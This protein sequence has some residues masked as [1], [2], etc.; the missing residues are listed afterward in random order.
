MI[1]GENQNSICG[2]TILSNTWL[3]TA[4]HCVHNYVGVQVRM[5]CHKYDRCEAI[6]PVSRVII[7]ADYNPQTLESDIAVIRLTNPVTFST[8]IQP[9]CLPASDLPDDTEITVMGWGL[10]STGA[11]PT[12]STALKFVSSSDSIR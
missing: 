2:A 1:D 8:R 4:A 7:H 5:G 3:V 9:A 11:N 12:I 6:R 10:T